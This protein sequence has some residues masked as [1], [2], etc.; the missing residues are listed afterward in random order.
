MM[1]LLFM[2]FFW[3]CWSGG[4][5]SLWFNVP[6]M[7]QSSRSK[8]ST[9]LLAKWMLFLCL[10][11]QSLVD[12]GSWARSLWCCSR[13]IPQHLTTM[14]HFNSDVLHRLIRDMKL[15]V[16]GVGPKIFRQ[17]LQV[18]VANGKS[19]TL[20][21]TLRLNSVSRFSLILWLAR[22]SGVTVGIWKGRDIVAPFLSRTWLG[23]QAHLCSSYLAC[24][25][26]LQAIT[27]TFGTFPSCI[28]VGGLAHVL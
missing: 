14:L 20:S 2:L 18:L 7:I 15:D 19:P 27:W 22:V 12:G 9:R 11:R 21:G 6:G 17:R 13:F 10:K 1:F 24:P 4:H 3:W 26:F 28:W 16:I 25:F 23:G 5:D 8:L